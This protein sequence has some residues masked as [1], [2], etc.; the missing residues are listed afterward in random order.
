MNADPLQYGLETVRRESG[1]VHWSR[2]FHSSKL[3]SPFKSLRSA[4]PRWAAWLKLLNLAE[5]MQNLACITDNFYTLGASIWAGLETDGNGRKRQ[6]KNS[7]LLS[8][9][10]VLNLVASQ[11]KYLEQKDTVA[12]FYYHRI[13]CIFKKN[14]IATT[15]SP[16]ICSKPQKG[17]HF[18]AEHTFW[19]ARPQLPGRRREPWETDWLLSFQGYLMMYFK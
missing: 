18:P 6:S 5:V 19:L 2:E 11:L 9:A 4:F 17:F 8:A 12:V 1:M 10:S 14:Q 16:S 15:P 3:Q 7:I 13:S